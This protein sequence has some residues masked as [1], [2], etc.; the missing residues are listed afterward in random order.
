MAASATSED[1]AERAYHEAFR[2]RL[3]G[4][5][6]D[7]GYS[8]PQM[9]EAL[10]LSLD[11]YKKYETRSKFPSHL[12]NKLALVTH[13]PLEFIVTGHGPNIRPIARRQT[14]AN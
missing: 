5:R 3:V 4:L 9:A 11:N 7:L 2:A 14:R 1:Q 12:L 8:Q 10:G 6:L 13:R